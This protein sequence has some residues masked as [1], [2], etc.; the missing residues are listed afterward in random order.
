MIELDSANA[1][2]DNT[3]RTWL[4]L[5]NFTFIHRN[6]ASGNNAAMLLRGKADAS[7]ANG[8]ITSPMACLRLSGANILAADAPNQKMGPPQLASVVMQCGSGGAFLGSSG[9][10]N[11]QVADV[12]NAGAHNNAA[13]TP[14]LT[15][16]FVNGANEAAVTVTDAKTID[17]A[18]ETT[19]YV[20]AVRDAS[21]TWYVGWTCSSGTAIST[22]S[23]CNSLP[24]L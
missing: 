1:L 4:K 17:T 19:D 11:E 23:S 20:G 10:T 6:P 2:E 14:S 13:F 5:A 22:G 16:H 3:P 21:D 7:L 9:I 12:F 15:D 8:V 24:P 18:F